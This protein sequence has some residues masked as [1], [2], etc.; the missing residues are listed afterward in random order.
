MIRI[1]KLWVLM[2]NT[3]KTFWSYYQ[4]LSHGRVMF[5][6]KAFGVLTIGK[7]IMNVHPFVVLLMLTLKIMSSFHIVGLEASTLL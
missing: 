2:G 4:D 7:L 6:W 5:Y 1:L 3:R